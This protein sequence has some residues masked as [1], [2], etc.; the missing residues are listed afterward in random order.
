MSIAVEVQSGLNNVVPRTSPE[1]QLLQTLVYF[2]FD[3]PHRFADRHILEN[4]LL[5]FYA[6][7]I[8][9]MRPR[10]SRIRSASRAWSGTPKNWSMLRPDYHSIALPSSPG[11]RVSTSWFR[12]L[13]TLVAPAIEEAHPAQLALHALEQIIAIGNGKGTRGF[14][15]HHSDSGDRAIFT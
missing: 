2:Q 11:R 7:A 10:P 13:R 8:G 4:L 1:L 14:F 12:W 3:S 5:T 9:P 15:S 6:L